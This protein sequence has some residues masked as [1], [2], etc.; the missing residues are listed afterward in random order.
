MESVKIILD[1]FEESVNNSN[2]VKPYLFKFETDVQRFKIHFQTR[3]A[4][5]GNYPHMGVTAREGIHVLY[6]IAGTTQWFNV[7]AYSPRNS[8][9]NVNMKYLA[10]IGESYEILIYGPVLSEIELLKIEIDNGSEIT[11]LNNE[12][13]NEVLIVG[14]IHTL[15]IGCTASGVMFSNILARR[16]DKH[17][18]NISFNETNHLKT[19]YEKIDN[20][21]LDKYDTII[22][23]L[24]Y[25]RQDEAVFDEYA[26][27]VIK[28]LK[29]KCN[30][31]ICWYALPKSESGRY[32]KLTEFEKKYSKKRNISVL[33]LSFIYDEDLSE[34]C[35]HSKNYINDTGNIII[36][37]ELLKQINGNEKEPAKSTFNER[38]RGLKNGIFKFN[39]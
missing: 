39:R 19:I 8:P 16:F 4:P 33:D 22:L 1:L 12:I 11:V 3:N 32:S 34:M 21:N 24:D 18:Q 23:E 30:N 29:S 7:D 10:Q 17:F 2:S 26:K 36:Y 9:V 25:I 38:L 6:R 14:G 27:K 15:G 20:Y 28:K 13:S 5:S 37:K 31:L 35:T